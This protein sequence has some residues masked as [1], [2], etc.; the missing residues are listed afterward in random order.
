MAAPRKKTSRELQ[1]VLLNE[2]IKDLLKKVVMEQNTNV[3]AYIESL[4]TE[5]HYAVMFDKAKPLDTTL[6]DKHYAGEYSKEGIQISM[7]PEIRAWLKELAIK[8]SMKISPYVELLILNK[9]EK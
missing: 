6:S 5:R 3:S 1:M 4:V 8:E 7:H 2:G 9:L